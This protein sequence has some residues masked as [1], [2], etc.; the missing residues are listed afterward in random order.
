M[1]LNQ[2]LC[3]N[4]TAKF[5]HFPIRTTRSILMEY[6]CDIPVDLMVERAIESKS[7]K[8]ISGYGNRR[9]GL[10]FQYERFEVWSGI[11]FL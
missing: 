3:N 11:L 1:F 10:G 4:E 7:G 2:F 6:R 5:R 9:N 8:K